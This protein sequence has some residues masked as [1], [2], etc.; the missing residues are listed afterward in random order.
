M[1]ELAEPASDAETEGAP[2]L[3]TP[4]LARA[5]LAFLDRCPTQGRTEAMALLRVC[6]ALDAIAIKGGR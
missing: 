5:A 2:A 1:N 3:L 6:A 4:D